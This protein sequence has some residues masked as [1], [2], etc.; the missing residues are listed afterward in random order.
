MNKTPSKRYCEM[1]DSIRP[2]SE[3]ECKLC[4]ADTIKLQTSLPT[5]ASAIRDLEVHHG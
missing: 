1:C 2:A 5:G 3:R 4:G